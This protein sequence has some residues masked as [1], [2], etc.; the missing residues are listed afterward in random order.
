M[1]DFLKSWMGQLALLGVL[2]VQNVASS[3]LIS[4]SRAVPAPERYVTSTVVLCTEVVKLV[5]SVVAVIHASNLRTVYLFFTSWSNW[6]NS[7]ALFFPAVVY[8]CTNNLAYIALTYLPAQ[9]FQ[10]LTQGKTLATAVF[11]VTFLGTRL[12]RIQWMALLLLV[13]GVALAQMPSGPAAASGAAAGAGEGGGMGEHAK[14]VVAVLTLCVLSGAAGIYQEKVLKQY[15]DLSIN[16]LNA[17]LAIFSIVTNGVAIFLQDREVILEHG[18]FHGYN[19]LVWSV[20]LVASLGGIMVSLVIRHTSNLA[21]TYAVSF[22]I[23]AVT[24]T[25]W[26]IDPTTAQ[27][28]LSWCLA[29][30]V[31]IISVLLF[32]DPAA[33]PPP[34]APSPVALSASSSSASTSTSPT[35]SPSSKARLLAPVQSGE[36][37]VL[38]VDSRGEGDSKST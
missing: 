16:Y 2:L 19:G 14:G 35:T 29:A 12:T 7:W 18:F 36:A 33:Q 25:Q 23:L 34:L 20:V 3:I 5:G 26:L 21:K 32:T 27:I 1:A 37:T 22:A 17:Q 28:T 4:R 31:V 30:M 15:I 24:F 13:M 11:A 9:E 38:E 10:L 8:T 6:R